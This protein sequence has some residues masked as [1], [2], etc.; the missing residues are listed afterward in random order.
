VSCFES[1]DF[2]QLFA[3]IVFATT[4]NKLQTTYFG[5]EVCILGFYATPDGNHGDANACNYAIAVGV[6]A[7]L[8]ALVF[9]GLDSM[10]YFLH[11]GNDLAQYVVAL[12]DLVVSLIMSLL[13]F[14]AFV[15]LTDKSI[16]SGPRNEEPFTAANKS[17]EGVCIA[18]SLFSCLVWVNFEQNSVICT[19]TTTRTMLFQGGLGFLAHCQSRTSRPNRSE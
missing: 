17:A 2:L 5:V 9:I 18:F 10:L 4:A 14:V 12:T 1:P 15:Y 19:C 8:F 7:F 3:I 6:M 16:N 13:W 11:F